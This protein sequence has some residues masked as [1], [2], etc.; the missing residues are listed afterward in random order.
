MNYMII[1]KN[2]NFNNFILIE[3]YHGNHYNLLQLKEVNNNLNKYTNTF[4]TIKNKIIL[5]FND[6]KDNLT[7]LK[8]NNFVNKYN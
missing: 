6:K 2:E 4:K 7:K 3:F 1:T 8:T 5:G